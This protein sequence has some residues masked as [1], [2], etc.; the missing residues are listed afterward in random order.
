VS[1]VHGPL[2]ALSL[3]E[4]LAHRLSRQYGMTGPLS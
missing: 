3:I 2:A 1:K 4:P